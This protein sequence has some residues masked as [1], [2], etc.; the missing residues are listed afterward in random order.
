MHR[1]AVTAALYAECAGQQGQFWP[2]HDLVIRDQSKWS[3]ITIVRPYFM[4]YA[5][6]LNL[7]VDVLSACVDDE[8]TREVIIHDQEEGRQLGIRSTP[9]YFINGEMIVGPKSL[10]D[11]M[12]ELLKDDK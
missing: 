4:N 1:H 9:T 10:Q 11:K 3:K 12:N 2:F 7:D 8:K 6:E 5:K